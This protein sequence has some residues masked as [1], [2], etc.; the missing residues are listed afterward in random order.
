MRAI[1]VQNRTISPIVGLGVCY[2]LFFIL[3]KIENII[4]NTTRE[5]YSVEDKLSIATIFIF[6]YK[7]DSRLFA[8]L[9]YSENHEEFLNKLSSEYADYEIDL[10]IRL[11]DKNVSNSFY[12]TL[13]K[14]KEKY[15]SNSFYKALFEK[16]SFAEVI[17]EMINNENTLKIIEL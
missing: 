10:S 11:S 2:R 1:H 5:I 8:E 4:Y 14:V 17:C 15:D 6:C 16:D 3:M 9:L 13:E 7:K 12:K